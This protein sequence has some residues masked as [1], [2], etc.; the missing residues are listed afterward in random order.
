MHRIALAERGVDG[1]GVLG[2]AG[3]QRVVGHPALPALAQEQRAGERGADRRGRR[4]THGAGFRQGQS[5]SPN[6]ILYSEPLA[7]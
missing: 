3:G 7:K 4:Q 5:V 2:H 6:K 1:I